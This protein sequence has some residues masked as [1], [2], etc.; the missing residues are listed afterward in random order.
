M[1]KGCGYSDSNIGQY[2]TPVASQ[3]KKKPVPVIESSKSDSDEGEFETVQLELKANEKK[4]NKGQPDNAPENQV[5]QDQL[6][7]DN[8][9]EKKLLI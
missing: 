2:Q 3:K 4:K 5:R 9:N 6:I 7:V 8:D 1:S